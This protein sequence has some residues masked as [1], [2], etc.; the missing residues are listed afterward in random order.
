MK[1]TIQTSILDTKLSVPFLGYEHALPLPAEKSLTSCGMCAVAMVISYKGHM[2]ELKD[3]IDTGHANGGF[4]Q[5]GW[6]HDYLLSVLTQYNVPAQRL[7]N[8]PLSK[9]ITMICES[10]DKENPVIISGRKLFMEQTSFHVVTVVGYRKDMDGN[11][12]G[13]FYHDPAI[14]GSEKASFKFVS[15]ENFIQFWRQMALVLE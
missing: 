9:G 2:I 5:N 15:K 14:V 13:F 3:L 10:I 7:E 4:T 8:I 6:G 1:Q 11:I 12:L